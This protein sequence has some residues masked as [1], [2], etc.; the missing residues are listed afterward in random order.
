MER[1][2]KLSHLPTREYRLAAIYHF[3]FDSSE[4]RNLLS[5]SLNGKNKVGPV[6][7]LQNSQEENVEKEHMINLEDLVGSSA[8][9]Y[10]PSD[11]PRNETTKDTF[12]FTLKISALNGFYAHTEYEALLSFKITVNV[13]PSD[14]IPPHVYTLRNLE[15]AESGKAQIDGSVVAAEDPDSL[16]SQLVCFVSRQPSHGYVANVDA[17]SPFYYLPISSFYASQIFEGKLAYVQ[18]LHTHRIRQ[19]E[20]EADI[21]KFFCSDGRNYARE[22]T[23]LEIKII[24]QNDE[25]PKFIYLK[26]INVQEGGSVTLGRPYFSL[27]DFDRPRRN[28]NITI[29][30]PPNYGSVMKRKR[31]IEWAQPDLFYPVSAFDT[32]QLILNPG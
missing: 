28:L 18:S 4:S 13:I 20:P 6:G 10:K 22:E 29:I 15:V 8:L 12:A 7:N 27:E 23:L 19:V 1:S 25:H 14:T 16:A 26:P 9:I 5:S 2:E 21:I 3:Y 24:P 30:R 32:S 11:T 31:I 17:S